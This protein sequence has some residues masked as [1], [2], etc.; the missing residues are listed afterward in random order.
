MLT[1]KVDLDRLAE[2]NIP[3]GVKF[4]PETGLSIVE[5]RS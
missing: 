2:A 5:T 1:L 3:M 4:V